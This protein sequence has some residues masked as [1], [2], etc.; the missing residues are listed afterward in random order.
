V[1]S[2]EQILEEYIA[3]IFSVDEYPK[4]ETS[5]KREA[6][7]TLLH[8]GFLLGLLFNPEHRADMLL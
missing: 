6:S 8:S 1:S 4:Q 2:S 7:K 3:S 5:M